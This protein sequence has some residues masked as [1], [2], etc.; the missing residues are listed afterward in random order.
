MP[1]TAITIFLPTVEAQNPGARLSRG[2]AAIV[3]I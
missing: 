3:L 2:T 1:V